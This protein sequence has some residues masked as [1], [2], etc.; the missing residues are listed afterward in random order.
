ME[1]PGL[2]SCGFQPNITTSSNVKDGAE[3]NLGKSA[4]TRNTGERIKRGIEHPN[5]TT[6]MHLWRTKVV[7]TSEIWKGFFL[8]ER[9]KGGA[10][11]E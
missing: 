1:K 7:R 2:T 6:F 10:N 5:E 11:K 8:R 4:A 9:S 3:K